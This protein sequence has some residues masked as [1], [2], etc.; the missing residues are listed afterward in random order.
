MAYPALNN[1]VPRSV[2]IGNSSRG[3]Y[4]LQDVSGTSIR[5]RLGSHLEIRRYSS[6]TD[7]TGTAL[8]LNTD[9]T[10]TNTNVDS[11]TI[12]LTLAQAVLTSSQRLVISRKQTIPDVISLAQGANF[13]GPT[14]AAAISV[15]TEQVQELRKDV[16]RAIK[17]DWRETTERAV[18]LPP[19]V[20]DAYLYR[21]ADG[22]IG[23]TETGDISTMAGL[24]TEIAALYAIRDDITNVSSIDAEVVIVSDGMADVETVADNIA[25]VNTV[26]DAVSA[27]VITTGATVGLQLTKF[28][29]WLKP[30]QLGT[31][32]GTADDVQIS[33]AIT[34]AFTNS[35]REVHL[36]YAEYAASSTISIANGSDAQYSTQNGLTIAGHPGRP[37][38]RL[39]SS[40][41]P[42]EDVGTRIKWTGAAGGTVLKVNGPATGIHL[43]DIAINADGASADA[44]VGLE[45]VSLNR[46]DIDGLTIA[47]ATTVGLR[48]NVIEADPVSGSSGEFDQ[49][50]DV[51]VRNLEIHSPSS[52][53][54]LQLDGFGGRRQLADCALATTA[55]ITLSGEQTIDGT[56][57]SSSRVLVR[58]Q[59]TASQNGIYTTGAGAWTRTTDA[60]AGSE[61]FY[62][63]VYITG[64]STYANKRFHCTNATTPSVGSDSITW[65]QDANGDPVRWKFSNSYLLQNLTSGVGID[66]GFADQITFD[67]TFMTFLGTPDGSARSIR[68]RGVKYVGSNFPQNIRMFHLDSGQ[69]APIEVDDSIAVPG[70]GHHFGW[71]TGFDSQA[72]LARKEAKY[73][74]MYNVMSG[75][76]PEGGFWQHQG[77]TAGKAFH[78]FLLNPRMI[79]QTRGSTGSITNGGFCADNFLFSFDGS[80]T[81][82]W[83]ITAL[84]PGDTTS[85]GGQMYKL[86][87]D[88]TAASGNTFF[89]IGQRVRASTLGARLFA[90]CS[91]TLSAYW[92]QSAG[93]ATSLVGARYEQYFG[94]G[95]SP[96][97]TVAA[98]TTTAVGY[99][100][101]ALSSTW[102]GLDYILTL[103]SVSGKTFGSNADDVL[104]IFFA[105]P[106]NAVCTLEMIAPQYELGRGFSCFDQRDPNW[107]EI[108][109][110]FTLRK[111]GKGAR[112]HFQAA[113]TSSAFHASMTLDPPMRTTPTVTSGTTSAIVAVSGDNTFTDSGT[114]VL[115]GTSRDKNGIE[116]S[117]TPGGTWSATPT[118][119][120]TGVLRT[121]QFLLSCE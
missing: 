111:V 68:L 93:S 22:T 94:T 47:G 45:L 63:T 117:I 28:T 62:T 12:T 100:T 14:L 96:S 30:Q 15:V 82:T 91:T 74:T 55:N 42:L 120:R 64:G 66:I 29:D 113:S 121:D 35:L 26:A 67:D 3:P 25:D 119:F 41:S 48:V 10:V 52:A 7:E 102:K 73:I 78:N 13:S 24:S 56:L 33:A 108:M 1:Q 34:A 60:D 38:L 65:T 81:G 98:N 53:I 115:S 46:S 36:D 32:D 112:G 84:S 109:C 80:I 95:G 72:V 87:L 18:P 103:P 86:T 118:A 88:I 57:T 6:T 9:Y 106:I 23:Q 4:T 116:I 101:N 89:Y 77:P 58:S 75:N 107:D 39:N 44:A 71:N 40:G 59:S 105:L 21:A 114:S 49:T 83:T 69:S 79:R 37:F 92:R 97:T 43:R 11:V 85:D 27:G 16:D 17:V 76:H 99:N 2:V 70:G 8:V 20:N 110:G 104:R 5:V 50:T 54:G 90:G 31:V 61:L 51:Q 19:A